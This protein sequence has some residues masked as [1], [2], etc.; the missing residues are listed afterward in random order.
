MNKDKPEKQKATHHKTSEEQELLEKK[1]KDYEDMLKRLQAEF[2]NFR[3]RCEKVQ[4][5]AVRTASQDLMT[6]LLPFLD[7]FDAALGSKSPDDGSRAGLEQL[8][9]QFTSV[10]TG[11]GLRPIEAIGKR[12]DPYRHEAVLKE[13]NAEID[14]DIITAE[15]QKGYML[16]DMV[17][18]HSKVRINQKEHQEHGKEEET[19]DAEKAKE[20]DAKK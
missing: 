18:R 8:H 11:A 15:I 13:N 4:A 3:K 20:G 6:R 17:L 7:S 14:D 5:L 16:N 2:E 10:L 9:R 1:C 12:F 19:G